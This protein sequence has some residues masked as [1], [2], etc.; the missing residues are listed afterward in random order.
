MKNLIFLLFLL[1]AALSA[2]DTLAVETDT[3]ITNPGNIEVDQVQVIKAFEAKLEDA[4]QIS[5]KPNIEAVIPKQKSY[6]YD[7][8]IV[9]LHIEYPDPVIKPLAMNPDEPKPVRNFYSRIGYGDLNSPYA[10]LSYHGQRGDEWDYTVSGHYYGADDSDEIKFRKFSEANLNIN[11]GYTLSENH[12]LSF[13]FAGALHSRNRYDTAFVNQNDILLEEDVQRRILTTKA[14]VGINTIETTEANFNYG[15]GLTGQR[16]KYSK[17]LEYSENG[18]GLDFFIDNVL[19]SGFKIFVKGEGAL[20]SITY[21]SGGTRDR[22][23]FTANPGIGL[24]IGNFHLDAAA[25][26]FVDGEQ[27]SPFVDIKASYSLLDNSLQIY[28]GV[29]QTAMGNTLWNHYANNPYANGFI[30]IDKTTLT[31]RYFGGVAGKLKDF[32]TFNFMGG[33]GDVKDQFYYDNV[34]IFRMIVKHTDMTNVF[35]SGNIEFNV[36]DEVVVG[37]N[38]TQNFFSLEELDRLPN[39]P[40][41]RYRGYSNIKL[42]E[43]KLTLNID[44][45]LMDKVSYLAENGAEILGNNQIDLSFG[46]DYFFTENFGLWVRAN[47]LLD[48]EY[49]RYNNYPE[50][51]RNF[52]GGLLVKF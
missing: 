30:E 5:L 17:N 47:N 4:K 52:L 21:A 39:T 11:V 35:L 13:D 14:R 1:P 29:D 51:G 44:I 8:T 41:F 50:F 22:K 32:L 42:L 26:F 36:S 33:Y 28:A 45:N 49:L 40:E 46:A 3:T 6:D 20:H 38:M 2:Q 15:V 23:A 16:I 18:I 7:I 31:R 37:A 10:D 27:T 19:S 48:R 12:K 24:T 9:P 34:A 25:D 43:D